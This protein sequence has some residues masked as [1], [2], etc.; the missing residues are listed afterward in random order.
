MRAPTS[1]PVEASP[2]PADQDPINFGNALATLRARWRLVAGGL[3]LALSLSGLYLFLTEPTYE[4]FS[5]VFVD[6]WKPSSLLPE[7]RTSVYLNGETRALVNEVE[8]L[9]QSLSLAERVLQHLPEATLHRMTEEA[10]L[11]PE[12]ASLSRIA[13]F[14]LEERLSFEAASD[15]EA[16]KLIRITAK[17]TDPEEAA[18]LANG[19]AQEYS[20]RSRESSRADVTSRRAFLEVQT[21]AQRAK[22]AEAES[23]LQEFMTQEQAIALDT[24][25]VLAVQQISAL[26]AALEETRVDLEV[27]R[28]AMQTL[29][30]EIDRIRPA[31]PSRV[32]SSAES[33]IAS[34][35]RQI[36]DLEIRASDYYA[37]DS[38]LR[39]AEHRDSELSSLTNRI[40]QARTRLHVLSE[41]Y[42]EEVL[43]AGGVGDAVDAFAGGSGLAYV[44]KLQQQAAEKTIRLRELEARR[45]SLQDQLR[46]YEV[47]LAGLP[48]Q[49]IQLAQLQRE[50]QAAEQVYLLL[51]RKLQDA[52]IAEESARGFVETIRAAL[53]PDEPSAPNLP[54]ILFLGGLL[55][56][57]V[58]CGLA[59]AF[60]A[61]D[62]RVRTLQEVEVA[63]G[64]P[65]IGTVGNLKKATETYQARLAD[66]LPQERDGIDPLVAASVD[67]TSRVAEAFRHLRTRIQL[68]ALGDSSSSLLVTSAEAG[69]GKTTVAL[70]LALSMAQLGRRTLY[71][72]ANLRH[73]ASQRLLG[74]DR[75][76]GLTDL[77]TSEEGAVDSSLFHC[78]LSVHLDAH[79]HQV[80]SL[81][82]LPAGPPV[83]NPTELLCSLRIQQTLRWLQD[84]FEFVVLDAPPA[85]DVTD[86]V[87][88]STLADAVL[89]VAAAGKTDRRLL[90]Q[91]ASVLKAATR[92]GPLGVV[93]NWHDA[94]PLY[95]RHTE[96]TE[97]AERFKS[98]SGA[99]L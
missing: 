30:E 51:S 64:L 54:L 43:E 83:S 68:G 82:V 65:V 44:T 7:E 39:G 93:L 60:G 23:R 77:L 4:A 53:V 45:A 67:P 74:I 38:T 96:F 40:E 1:Y 87:V 25:G 97:P 90:A 62:H 99:R 92:Q 50:R 3:V 81:Y 76:P 95:R 34:L 19:Y 58:G 52:G 17:S 71:V 86:A 98:F 2:Q 88:L 37:A 9:R 32:R 12:Q 91:A 56:S 85:L 16:A 11:T 24:E 42:V 63:S 6:T 33:E 47:G 15:E 22:L 36:A 46:Q 48:A 55:G 13:E 72:D 75:R 57:C 27:E 70:N 59:L 89:L 79:K 41:Q 18:A 78:P 10:D 80:N 61:L 5:V 69:E 73:P 28:V 35:Q 31:L 20:L 66:V 21:R 26:D 49:S 94:Q 8:I 14:M 84:E 29:Q